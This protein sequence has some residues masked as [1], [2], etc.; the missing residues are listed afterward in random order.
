MTIANAATFAAARVNLSRFML[1]KADNMARLLGFGYVDKDVAPND[2]EA[3]RA[4]WAH[5]KRT[6]LALP[7]WAGGSDKTVYTS[8]GANYAFRFWHDSLHCMHGLGFNTADEITIGIMQTAEVATYF[9]PDSLESKIM[10]ADTVEQSRYAARHNGEF[11]DDQLAFV[12][13]RVLYPHTAQLLAE[14][15]ADIC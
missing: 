13:S 3:L 2:I 1:S 12:T 11:P 9:G 8:R 7:V 4:A 6:G 10:F 14:C 15:S 5:S